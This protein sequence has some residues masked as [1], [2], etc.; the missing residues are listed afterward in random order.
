MIKKFFLFA[1]L[2]FATFCQ[3]KA[4]S[5]LTLSD[6]AAK[7]GETVTMYVTTSGPLDAFSFAVQSPEGIKLSK[8]QRGALIKVYNDDD[9]YAFTF[10][11]SL[12]ED[13]TRYILC[14]SISKE[15][16]N[17][18]GEVVKLVFEIDSELA[19]GIY[20]I[21]LL[22][23]ECSLGGAMVN[24][25]TDYTA[26]LMV[27]NPTTGI[28][29]VSMSM[30]PSG[31]V[32]IYN[33]AGKIVKQLFADGTKAIGEYMTGMQAGVYMIKTSEGTYKVAK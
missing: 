18:T 30:A 10:S 11:N 17:E 19:S 9:E 23:I 7:T 24:T 21:K 12:R 33:L 4:A 27:T 15:A 32:V 13:G 2:V 3:S 29:A 28:G 5:D 22:E 26:S 31:N 14:Y 25:Y 16:T 20:D 1:V 8:V 6:T